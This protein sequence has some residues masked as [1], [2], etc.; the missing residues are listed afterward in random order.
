MVPR[1]SSETS[2][3]PPTAR[4]PSTSAN[5]HANDDIQK[6]L[7]LGFAPLGYVYKH[8]REGGIAGENVITS[9]TVAEAALAV[10]RERP[11]QAR[12]RRSQH[13]GKLYDLIFHGLNPT[14]ALTAV[15]IYRNVER[16]RRDAAD[17][18]PAYIPYAS[19]HLAML[20]GREI[21]TDL[22]ISLTDL[23]HHH[24]DAAKQTLQANGDSYY[25]RANATIEEAI[26][27]C[28]GDRDISLQQL[29]ATSRRGD[30]LEMLLP[31]T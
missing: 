26:H 29:A 6:T 28:Y 20:I 30:L 18:A 27:A 19:H 7:A 13:F 23:T 24:F 12:F 10:W 8:H 22:G 1:T 5:L 31:A 17:D 3:V 21:R 15:L 4:A 2:R 25:A 9:A 14:A 16:R 11:H